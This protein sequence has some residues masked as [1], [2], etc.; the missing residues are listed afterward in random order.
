MN[1]RSL[2]SFDRMITPVIIQILFWVG[3]AVSV[4]AGIAMM[5]A[6]CAANYGGGAQ[7]FM[8][9]VTLVVGPLLTR[10]YCELLILLFKIFDRLGD[11]Q[12]A[13]ADSGAHRT[14]AEQQAART[15][16]SDHP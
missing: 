14:L 1:A 16:S 9:L 4:L 5:I 3:V 10:V 6:G 7:V 11:I 8:G 2:I 12:M 15:A 13:L